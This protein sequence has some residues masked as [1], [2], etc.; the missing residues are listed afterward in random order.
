MKKTTTLYKDV[1]GYIEAVESGKEIANEDIKK[2]CRL[3]KT[4]LDTE[5]LILEAERYDK[6]IGVAQAMYKE[7]FPWERFLIGVSL[8]IYDSKHQ[9]RWHEIMVMIGRGNGKDGIIASISL[10]MVSRHNPIRNYDVDIC[11]NNEEQ[12]VRPVQDVVEFLEQPESVIRNKSSFYWTK[13]GVQGLANRGRIKGHTNSP[14]GKDGLRSGCVVLNEVHQY[15]DYANIDVFTTGLGKKAEPRIFM[16]TTNGFVRDGVLDNKLREAD[17][18]LNGLVADEGRLYL[19]YRLDNK[20]EVHDEEMWVKANP[21]LPYMPNLLLEIRREYRQWKT[22]PFNLPGFMA[23]RMNLPE[24]A[25]ERA[26]VDYEYIKATNQPLIDLA[27]MSCV[28][29]VDLSKTT[30]M[31]S[32]SLLFKGN[33]TRYV[34]NHSWICKAS[35]DWNKI[36][37]RDRFPEWEQMGLLTI[38][39]DLEINP[40]LVCGWINQQKMKYNIQ[41]VCMDDFRQ[42]IFA[43]EL[44]KIGFTKD[45]KNVKFVRLTDVAK[46]VPVIESA[47]L[48]KT[49]VWGDNPV[50]RWATNNTKVVPFRTRNTSDGDLGSFI[51][52][53]IEHRSRKTDPF[54]SLVHAMTCDAELMERVNI[55]SSIFRAVSFS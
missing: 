19:L 25:S 35:Q 12:S 11:A 39:D 41:K 8:C 40:A 38:V 2:Q 34:I 54:M 28:C 31:C 51:Y 36:K 29:G 26:V 30:D 44:A 53:K 37:V 20:D 5:D 18:V 9:P 16:F 48:N 7:V 49:F 21:S 46:A 10:A 3:V 14:K 24:T 27:G 42:S 15:E 43:Y 52:A 23:K 22:A 17:D 1:V 4:A 45:R 55:D 32:A 47:F 13:E 50:L 6:Y 33:G